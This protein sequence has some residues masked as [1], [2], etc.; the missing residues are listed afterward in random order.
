MTFAI[1]FPSIDPVLVEIGPFAIRWYALAY[2][3]GLLLGW[4][5]MR[6]LARRS[7]V[8]IHRD[9]IGDFVVW[10]TLG[11]LLGGRLGYVLFYNL[12]HYI[13]H[14]LTVFAVWRGGMS[15]DGGLLGVLVATLLFVHRRGIRF[16]PFAD[17]IACA[18]PIGL[19][20][21]RIAN[22]INGELYGRMTDVPWAVVFPDGGPEPRH[23]SQLYE[24]TLEGLVLFAVLYL[25]WRVDYVRRRW[26]ILTGVFLAGYGVARI[27][28]EFFRQPDSQIGFLLGGTTNG[29]WPSAPMVVFGVLFI[30]WA[31]SRTQK[32]D[33]AQRTQ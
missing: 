11:V 9:D 24:A 7:P 2:V 12:D 5:Y 20:F 15:F 33:A 6:L 8:D 27:T 4:R 26:G 32:A 30:V 16:L 17:L 1:A 29:Q 23:P 21:G 10:A 22:F 28:V 25:L 19:F 3:A 18:A 13:Q 31:V 14:P